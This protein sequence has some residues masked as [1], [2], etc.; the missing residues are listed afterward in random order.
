MKWREK[1]I[2]HTLSKSLK[3]ETYLYIHENMQTVWCVFCW[4]ISSCKTCPLSS[5]KCLSIEN[6]P[7]EANGLIDST[8]NTADSL[9]DSKRKKKEKNETEFFCNYTVSFRLKIN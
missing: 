3:T 1:K 6:W 4:C 8:D 7:L 2:E 5:L 9:C